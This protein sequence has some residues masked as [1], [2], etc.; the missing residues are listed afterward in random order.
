MYAIRSYYGK[1][2]NIARDSAHQMTRELVEFARVMGATTLVFERLKGWRPKGPR[3]GLRRKFHTWLHR[4]IVEFS[5]WK[6]REFAGRMAFVAARG[7]SK[8][9]YDGS[10]L[11]TRNVGGNYS[12]CR[13]QNGKIFV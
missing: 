6:W 5:E 1:G 2:F 11:V 13:F 4:R 10:G 12:L 3:Y 9:A 8:Y 7:T